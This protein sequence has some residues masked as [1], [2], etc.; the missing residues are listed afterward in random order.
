MKNLFYIL[1]IFSYSN[2][3]AQRVHEAGISNL[4]RVLLFFIIVYYGLKMVKRYVFPM[5]LTYF[6]NKFSQKFNSQEPSLKEGE[7]VIDKKPQQKNE[8]NTVGEYIDFE[9]IE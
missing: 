9:E 4:F 6:M 8:S 3:S 7:T 1:F 5:I 2:A